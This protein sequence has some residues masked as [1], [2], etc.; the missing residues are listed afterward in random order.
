MTCQQEHGL[1]DAAVHSRGVTG[2]RDIQGRD[3]NDKGARPNHHRQQELF[4]E[5][6]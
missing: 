2:E 4:K 6:D 3:S 5:L 1:K